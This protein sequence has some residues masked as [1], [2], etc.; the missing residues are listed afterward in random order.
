MKFLQNFCGEKLVLGILAS[1]EKFYPLEILDQLNQN[2]KITFSLAYLYPIFNRLEKKGL[3][4]CEW[5]ELDG[6]SSCRRK[7]YKLARDA[8]V[9]NYVE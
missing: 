7:Y 9:G 2:R 8:T 5:G 3:V 4:E 1:G 6:V